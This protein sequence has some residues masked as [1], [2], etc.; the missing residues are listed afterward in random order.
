VL[1]RRED[2]REFDRRA[3]TFVS[4]YPTHPYCG[5]LVSKLVADAL[6][7]GQSEQAHTWAKWLFRELPGGNT[8]ELTLMRLAE[9]E[10]AQ[11]ALARDIYHDVV[12]RVRDRDAKLQ[13]RLGLAKVALALDR[14]AEAQQALGGFLRE[15]PPDDP[16]LIWAFG[17]LARIYEADGQREQ[18]LAT[19]EAFVSRF[20]GEPTVPAFQLKRGELLLQLRQWGPA[21]EALEAARNAGEP[22]VAAWAHVRL[23]ELHLARDNPQAAIEDYLGAAY[24]YPDSPPAGLGLQGAAQ[25]YLGLKMPREARILL[26][27]LATRPAVDPRRSPS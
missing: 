2:P 3:G 19:V 22:A 4:A 7:R 20:P 21:R 15:A 5:I 1:V 11:P 13:A 24:V 9:A 14:P 23:G 18:A 6:A 10:Y 16:R 8:V 12:A 25:G 27:K 17:Q 26:E